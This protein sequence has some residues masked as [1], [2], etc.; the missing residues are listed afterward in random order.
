MLHG[1]HML[2]PPCQNE[3]A[4]LQVS[5]GT[6]RLC[7]SQEEGI[8]RIEQMAPAEATGAT[9]LCFVLVG[10]GSAHAFCSAYDFGP[11][12]LL[13]GVASLQPRVLEVRPA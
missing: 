12:P 13:A 10:P 1:V 8:A 7:V 2:A 4:R 5:D 3:P 9:L 6:A 11:W